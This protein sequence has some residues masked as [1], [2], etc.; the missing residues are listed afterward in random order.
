MAVASFVLVGGAPGAARADSG[1]SQAFTIKDPRITE[2]SGLAASHRHP[3]VYWTHNDSGD[4][5]Y[6][7]AVDAATGRTV[8]RVT[9]R[10]VSVRDCEAISVGPDGDVYLGD[11]GDNLGGT[12]PQVWIYRFRE[13]ATLRDATVDATRY[14]VRYQGGPRDAESLMV[15]PRTGRVYIASKDEDGGGLYEGPARLS[16]SGINV[17]RRIA[18]V[19]WVTDGSFSPDGSRLVLR[20]YFSATDYRWRDGRPTEI[21][22]LDVPM[23]R[24]GESVT[25]TRDGRALM[26]GSE[27][28]SSEVWRI[29]LSGADLPD[30]AAKAEKA[31]NAAKGAQSA[32]GGKDDAA[33]GAAAGDKPSGGFGAGVMALLVATAL[34]MGARKLLRR[35]R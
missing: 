21:G 13:P 12:W 32:K 3:G 6:V 33:G 22:P 29:P 9:L 23:Q 26:V 20:G 18:G 11:I 27:G 25:Y 28:D 1:P 35:G 16:A 4:G 5:P 7:Y 34:A 8:A 19:P 31:A 15:D 30:A 10:G 24:Q 2:S 17:F 14:T